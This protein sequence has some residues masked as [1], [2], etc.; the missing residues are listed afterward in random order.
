MGP[1]LSI[2]TFT[3]LVI[4]QNSIRVPTPA[5]PKTTMLV[6]LSKRYRKMMTYTGNEFEPFKPI[7]IT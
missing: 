3:A 1:D 5:L 6:L 2:E 4:F 7:A